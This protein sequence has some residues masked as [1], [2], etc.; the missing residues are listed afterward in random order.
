MGPRDPLR[1]ALRRIQGKKEFFVWL[2]EALARPDV[3]RK[4]MEEARGFAAIAVQRGWIN[5]AQISPSFRPDEGWLSFGI[6]IAAEGLRLWK[7]WAH[8]NRDVVLPNPFFDA[9]YV[10]Y[11]AIADGLL[12]CDRGQLGLAWAVWPAKR[13]GLYYWDQCTGAERP[14]SLD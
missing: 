1:N 5:Q 11:V 3:R 6:M 13:N 10:A 7:L 9:M 4:S 8:Q 12:S 14:F 2:A